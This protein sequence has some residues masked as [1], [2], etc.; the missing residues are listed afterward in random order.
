M[1]PR[2]GSEL[3]LCFPAISLLFR[4]ADP[5]MPIRF[6]DKVIDCYTV[7]GSIEPAKCCEAPFIDIS[8]IRSA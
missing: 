6:M 5:S 1:T 4:E 3:E 2:C 8:A 7:K